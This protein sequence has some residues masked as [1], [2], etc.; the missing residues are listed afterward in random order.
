MINAYNEFFILLDNNEI[1]YYL[2][3]ASLAFSII[4]G[5]VALAK[6]LKKQ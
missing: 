2:F 6:E 3:W 5:L 1:V 4:F